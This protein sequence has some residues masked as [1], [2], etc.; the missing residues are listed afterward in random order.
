MR[1]II[2]L[3]VLGICG[4]LL[5]PGYV[6]ADKPIDEW[7]YDGGYEDSASKVAVDSQ[8][9][10]YVTGTSDNGSGYDYVTVKYDTKGKELWVKRYD[11]G[12]DDHV[13]AIVV[14]SA[15]NVCITG[16]SYSASGG[17]D[18]LTVKYDTNGNESWVKRYDSGYDDYGIAIAVDPMG[19]VYVS[20][21]SMLDYATI[22]YDTNGNEL[23]IK[24]YDSGYTDNLAGL[25]ID[26]IGN[27]YVTGTSYQDPVAYN[28][29]KYDVNGNELWVKKYTDF[30]SYGSNANAITV[31]MA[32]NVFV[33]GS[34]Y[35]PSSATDYVTIKYDPN[36]N[37]LWIRRYDHSG[38]HD[39]PVDLAVDSMGNVYV[40]GTSYKDYWYPD[41]ATVK[42]DTDG[43]QLWVKRY[44]NTGW[45][46]YA[47]ALAVDSSGDVYVTGTVAPRPFDYATVKYDT[48]GNELWV[49]KFENRDGRYEYNASASDI[50]VD[51]LGN[52]YVTGAS[53]SRKTGGYDFTTI[54]YS[55]HSKLQR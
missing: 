54:K 46:S 6:L 1:S 11:G 7:R 45:P 32:G 48:N 50:T 20:G 22:K 36:G 53:Y 18:F 44:S 41:Y 27:V 15:G 23:W 30:V 33:I 26:S 19:K 47:V 28:S 3:L 55:A 34:S 21:T 24:R 10:V 8:G 25:A 29:I 14:D 16:K 4:V 2:R 51:P 12:Y 31:D 40:T 9:S 42:Y 39:R 17:Y 37:E 5:V 52:V 43:N 13:N 35:H 38:Y 49:E